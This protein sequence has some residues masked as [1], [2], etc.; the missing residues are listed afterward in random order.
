MYLLE[1]PWGGGPPAEGPRGGGAPAEGPGGGIHWGGDTPKVSTK[2]R[3]TIQSPRNII[4][5]P[6]Y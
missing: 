3:Q 6:E 4:Q 5:S 2:P 1:A